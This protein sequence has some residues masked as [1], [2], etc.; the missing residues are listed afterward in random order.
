ME[1]FEYYEVLDDGV[2]FAR[3]RST[4]F[5]AL[6]SPHT[7]QWCQPNNISFMQLMHD[8]DCMEIS[9]ED[10]YKKANGSALE[11]LFQEYVSLLKRNQTI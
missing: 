2:V 6:Y 1:F 9:K 4:D 11:S 5:F 3:E 10:A 7:K 8:R